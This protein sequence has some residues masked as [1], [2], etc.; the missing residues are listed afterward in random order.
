MALKILMIFGLVLIAA[1]SINYFGN[2]GFNTSAQQSRQQVSALIKA[3]DECVLI[4]ERASAHLIPKL[5]FQRMELVARKASVVVRCMADHHFYQNPAWLK[6][7]QPLAAKIAGEQHISGDN[8]RAR[9]AL[10]KHGVA[11]PWRG[12]QKQSVVAP[13]RRLYVI[14]VAM[15]A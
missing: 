13:A 1:W 3:G 11:A 2:S 12:L 14:Q 5:E 7:A 4:S 6:Y 9:T 8:P 10:W 15:A